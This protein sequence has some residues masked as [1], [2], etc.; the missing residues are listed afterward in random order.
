MNAILVRLRNEPALLGAATVIAGTFGV[1]V[2]TGSGWL[3]FGLAVGEFVVALV[4][5]SKVSPVS[6]P[7]VGGLVAPPHP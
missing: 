6:K 4:V 7:V 5:R 2:P 1:T 3:G